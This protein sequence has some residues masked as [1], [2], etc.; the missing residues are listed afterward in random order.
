METG[1]AV[2]GQSTTFA[3][4]SLAPA[5]M[6]GLTD[7]NFTSP[8]QIQA[9]AIPYGLKGHDVLGIARTG[10][11]KTAAFVLP[12]MNALVES[13]GKMPPRHIRALILAPTRELA[14]QID[15]AIRQLGKHTRLR[16]FAVLGGVGRRP[17]VDRIFR[18]VDIVVGTPGRI[19]DL[20]STG[21]LRLD[22]VSH[23]VLDEAD[24]MLDF[25]FI[26]DV[27]KI[28]NALPEDRQS[29]LFSATMPPQVASL[30]QTLLTDPVR[31]EVART[32]ETPAKIDQHV[33][34]VEGGAKQD[35]LVQLLEDKGITRTIVFTRT[36]HGANRL[37]ENLFK[38][39]IRSEAL[40]GNKSQA[41]RQK[42]LD[43]FRAGES[44]VLI[45]TDIAARGID[46]PAVSHVIN[47]DIPNVPESYV[48]RIGRTAR[49]GASGVAVSFC[50]SDEAGY[51]R[52]IQRLTGHDLDI[53]AGDWPTRMPKRG[54][55]SQGRRPP[56]QRDG[57]S[58]SFGDRA[59]RGD[60]PF[61]DRPQ[62]DGERSFG[63]RPNRGDRPFG[64]RPQ[65]DGERSFGDRPNRGDRPFGDRPQRDGERSFGDRP[66]RG[67]RPFG[68]RPQRADRPFGD[69]PQGERSFGDRPNR[70]DRP[71]GDRPQRADRPFGDRPQ[72]E[73]SFGDRPNRGDRPFGDRPQRADRPFGDRPQRD[74]ERSFGDRPNRGDRPFGDRPQGE[75]S[76]G[77]KPARRD[78]MPRP[79]KGKGE[80][81]AGKGGDFGGDRPYR[82][83]DHGDR[84]VGDRP[85]KAPRK[86]FGDRPQGEKKSFGGKK[87]F[88]EKSAFSKLRKT[89]AA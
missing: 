50:A 72:G 46:I 43:R 22:L 80:F 59:P 7:N 38:A 55:A 30:A 83:A 68:D 88:G 2:A 78:S 17:Q 49:N 60:R 40:H 19:N 47:Y 81:A 56:Q 74:G 57:Q 85:M 14:V 6:Q 53:L 89:D 70:G 62:R 27:R 3:S 8:T 63:D 13:R 1:A 41:A 42:S 29:M 73:R 11:G 5:L 4:L 48:H 44:R 18:G 71:F 45:A 35:L 21:D 69:R 20:M 26:H 66:N 12:M 10:T 24:Q 67:D 37:S 36:K 28:A 52:D 75:R 65:R 86:D 33:Y 32:G 84:P 51:L 39:G 15:D 25:G 58:R 64:D 82:A 76:F 34:F 16:S 61:G 23:F 87:A 79:F 9:E 54:A 31:V 77:D